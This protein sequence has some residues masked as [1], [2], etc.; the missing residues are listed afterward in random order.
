MAVPVQVKNLLPSLTAVPHT[1]AISLDLF[2]FLVA[3]A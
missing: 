1:K 3:A 2:W